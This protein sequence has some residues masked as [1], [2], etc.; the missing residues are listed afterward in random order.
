MIG[1]VFVFVGWTWVTSTQI[2]SPTLEGSGRETE[3]WEEAFGGTEGQGQ[4]Y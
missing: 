1:F 2:L 4:C 3:L